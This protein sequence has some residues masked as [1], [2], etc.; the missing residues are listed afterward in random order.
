MK[1]K[2]L[3]IGPIADHHFIRFVKHL[4]EENEEALIDVLSYSTSSINTIDGD[5]VNN[6]RRIHLVKVGNSK[7]TIIS[8]IDHI[9]SFR[10]EVKKLASSNRY[11]FTVIHY[12][13]FYYSFCINYLKRMSR[14]IVLSPW[15]SDVY[16]IGRMNRF[17]LK[18]LYDNSDFVSGS[19]NR[20]HKDVQRIFEVDESKM[21][22]L[23]M[24]ADLFDIIS[25]YGQSIDATAARKELGIKGEY[26]ITC[27]YGASSS[28]NHRQVIEAISKVKNELPKGLTII[29][30]VTYPQNDKYVAKL[31]EW[32]K[33]QGLNGVFF[34]DY[35]DNMKMFMLRQATDMYIH[36]LVSDASSATLNEYLL[37]GKKVINASWLYYDELEKGGSKP[38]F[39]TENFESLPDTI[40]KAFN[41]DDAKIDESL[42]NHIKTKGWKYRIKLWNDF[43]NKLSA[44]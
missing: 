8:A 43:F 19:M 26:F 34:T 41:S 9:T 33:E 10:K 15:G 36:M 39:V 29:F 27:G 31:R 30:P 28:H 4:K 40:L 13:Q 23:G 11:D 6:S 16:R 42:K 38:Y 5:V 12:P 2:V 24:G 14:F 1:Y 37:L 17:I 44:N 3:V 7:N 35:L 22:V 18:K 21:V 25:E 32:T 20:F